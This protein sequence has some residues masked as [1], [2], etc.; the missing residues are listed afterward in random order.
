MGLSIFHIIV[1]VVFILIFI[2]VCVLIFLKINDIKTAIAAYIA[3]FTSIAIVTYSL[4]ITIDDY[5]IQAEVSNVNF[6]RNLSTESA[7]IRGRVTNK[8]NFLIRK[9]FLQ[10][11]V[12]NK[13]GSSG[14]IFARQPQIRR[15]KG[16]SNRVSYNL[17]IAN[18][19]NANSY[20]DFSIQIP[21]PPRFERVEFYHSLTCI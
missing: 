3:N 7:T 19:L 8:T 16:A 1:L 10:V 2:L 20:E 13:V 9:C 6:I 17:L 12:L 14:D 4:F 18:P 5:M 11:S 15:Q 21:L